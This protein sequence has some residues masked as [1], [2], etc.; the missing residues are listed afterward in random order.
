MKYK[1]LIFVILLV[2]ANAFLFKNGLWLYQDQSYWFKNSQEV[3]AF[4]TNQ[5]HIFSNAGYYLGSDQSI[6]AFNT[7]L[8]NI[9]FFVLFHLFGST[10]SQIAT[11]I[12][13]FILSFISFYLFSG[14]FFT[15]KKIRFI[16]TLL[17]TFNPLLYSF[18]GEGIVYATVPLFIYSFYEFYSKE[19]IV[20]MYLLLNVFASFLWI[21]N[22]RF[23]QAN[24]FLVVPLLVYLL[25]NR[26][27]FRIQTRKIIIFLSLYILLFLPLIYTLQA[28][29]LQKTT[30]IFGFSVVFNTFVAKGNFFD[31]FNFF[32]SSNIILYDNRLYLM[33]GIIF[34]IAFIIGFIKSIQKK[35][36]AFVVMNFVLFLLGLT[37]FKLGFVAG[38]E[39]YGFFIKFLP[40]LTNAPFYGL[41]ISNIP[42][43]LLLGH[44]SNRK[45]RL[46]S[47]FAACFIILATLPLLNLSDFKLQKFIISDIP[48]PYRQNFIQPYF[49]FAEAADYFPSSCWR[50]KYMDRFNTP[51]QCFNNGIHY[52]PI[53]FDNPR[54]I[55]GKS[56]FITKNIIENSNV[57]NLRITENVKYIITANDIVKGVDAGPEYDTD[58]IVKTNKVN[59]I[60]SRNSLLKKSENEYFTK[61]S[62]KNKN[63]YDFLVY[64]PGTVIY[65][66]DINSFFD[67]LLPIKGKPVVLSSS[68]KNIST[69][70]I[71]KNVHIFY[72]TS[73]LDPTTYYIQL[74]HV[75]TQSPFAIHLTQS[76]NP[77]WQVIWINKAEFYSKQCEN[78]PEEFSLTENTRCLVP[79]PLIDIG[80]LSLVNNP[81]VDQRNHFEGNYL[82]NTWVI[83]PKD[84]PQNAKGDKELYV[85]LI[86][87][88]Q[89][90]FSLTEIISGL[91][92]CLLILIVITQ[93]GKRIFSNKKI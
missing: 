69:D 39:T 77:A 5:F 38:R 30:G 29:L 32:Q 68:E 74:S 83:D 65:K 60:F 81:I 14:L 72:K 61:Y 25:G 18:R 45:E 53:S 54:A 91:A 28:Q 15:N 87:R 17:Y 48:K 49:G 42:L 63:D 73:Q 59:Q 41:Y 57:N 52:K 22:I 10:G 9:L 13:S 20:W 75:A 6:I 31:M 1:I 11:S 43:L 92:L 8:I 47:I 90:Y 85:I 56:Y 40:F 58:T 26:Q 67:N 62:F 76:F 33:L 19:K 24:F 64:S 82:S 7:I 55:S 44:M 80:L 12:L 79:Q 34:F 89:I 37:F 2:S 93:E 36:S 16:T 46:L 88:N 78:K 21:A 71:Q 27:G 23:L 70:T 4:L 51:T 86:D 84:I 35:Q 66:D 3:L 50:A